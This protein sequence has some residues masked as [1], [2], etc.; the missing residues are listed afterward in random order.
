LLLKT[1]RRFERAGLLRTSGKSRSL[2]LLFAIERDA[3]IFFLPDPPIFIHEKWDVDV[4]G[5]FAI[6]NF[7]WAFAR[8]LM[9]APWSEKGAGDLSGLTVDSET[10]G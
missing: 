10:S 7:D 4:F 9:Y 5:R 2:V 3:F 8:G 6:R 1:P